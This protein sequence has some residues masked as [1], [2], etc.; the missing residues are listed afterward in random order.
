MN[1]AFRNTVKRLGTFAT[2]VGFAYIN[3]AACLYG[4]A[5]LIIFGVFVGSL[6]FKCGWCTTVVFALALVSLIGWLV[7]AAVFGYLKLDDETERRRR[8]MLVAQLMLA[9]GC[10]ILGAS[11]N[12]VPSLF[13]SIK[14]VF[15]AVGTYFV[16][17]SILLTK[18][19]LMTDQTMR[20]KTMK[21]F[22]L[23]NLL[24]SVASYGFAVAFLLDMV[25]GGRSLG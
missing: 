2:K 19:G 10:V 17:M 5:I 15:L 20:P 3:L 8:E 22:F 13:W 1:L 23:M 12:F 16:G 9:F 18:S 11:A 6:L 14:V 4:T 25:F 24:A 21:F 7:A